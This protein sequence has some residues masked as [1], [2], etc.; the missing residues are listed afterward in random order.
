MIRF[1]CHRCKRPLAVPDRK[2]VGKKVKCPGCAIV[3]I[4]PDIP[5]A[6]E[7]KAKMQA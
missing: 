7:A 1:R 2:F 3:T 6:Q 5:G 4:V